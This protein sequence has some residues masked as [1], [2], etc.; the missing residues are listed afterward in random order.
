VRSGKTNEACG[1]A[2]I[3]QSGD[4]RF[5]P[6]HDL[7]KT[8]RIEAA[9]AWDQPDFS[10]LKRDI[11][12]RRGQ[13]VNANGTGQIAG[14]NPSLAAPDH[15]RKQHA[16]FAVVQPVAYLME[17]CARE[18]ARLNLEYPILGRPLFKKEPLRIDL[19]GAKVGSS[20]VD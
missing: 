15:A 10:A 18:I 4:L 6:A 13:F 11:D 5:F 7:W 19:V 12:Y 9:D 14:L 20:P 16:S 8:L 3:E 1:E 17:K 2:R